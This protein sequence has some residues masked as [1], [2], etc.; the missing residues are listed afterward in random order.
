MIWCD[1][2]ELVVEDLVECVCGGICVKLEVS[3]FFFLIC[4]IR[5][6]VEKWVIVNCVIEFLRLGDVVFVDGGMMIL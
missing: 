2:C 5:K 4:E 6:V 3:S 1:F